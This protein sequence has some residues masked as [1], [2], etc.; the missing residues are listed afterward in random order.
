MSLGRKNPSVSDTVREA[1]QFHYT[2]IMNL[3]VA[4][5]WRGWDICLEDLWAGSI[6]KPDHDAGSL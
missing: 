4:G 3:V 5:N 6:N 2:F 1:S